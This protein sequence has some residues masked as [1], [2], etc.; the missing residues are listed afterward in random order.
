MRTGF[1]ECFAGIS[2][3]M[4]LGALIDAGVPHEVMERAVEALGI[5]ARLRFSKV[6]RSGI[7]ATK[8]DVLVGEEL[9]EA[10]EHEPGHA[11]DHPHEHAHSH[12]HP[13]DHEHEP[14][15]EHSHDHAHP[16]VHGRSWRQI[17]ELISAAG[18]SAETRT[19]ALRAFEHLAEAEGRIHGMP[20]E[21]VH[22][23]EV[24]SVDAIVDI[25]CSAAGLAFLNVEHWTAAPI[26]VGSGMVECAHGLYPVPAPATLELL[27]G[28]PTYSAGPAVEM[29]TPTGAALLRA[30]SPSFTAAARTSET[31]GYGAGT[32]NPARFPNVLRLSV[33]NLQ[34]DRESGASLN[35][36]VTEAVSVVECALDDASP[37]LIA[38]VMEQALAQGALDV[39]AAPVTMKKSRLGTLLTVLAPPELSRA[40]EELLLRETTT[41]GLRIREEKRRVLP[42]R[43]E[44]VST[45]YGR[46]AIKIAGD[47]GNIMPEFEDCRRAALAHDVPLKHVQQAAITAYLSPQV[48]A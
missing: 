27:R 22:F 17:R 18:L 9:A 21:D 10:V 47:N 30:L 45:E 13:H 34:G 44:T 41:L 26:N 35:E 15:H 33:G 14:G 3:D 38:H 8:V 4:M 37:Q 16:H 1:L 32:R 7:R 19:L 20:A 36:A 11:H 23:H 25:V 12:S 39:M 46:I 42:R 29:V 2:G 6:D 31:I 5:G 24:G 40:L 48:P 28:M 43:F